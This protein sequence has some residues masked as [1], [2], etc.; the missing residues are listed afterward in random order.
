MGPYISWGQEDD[1]D[2]GR[3]I[4]VGLVVMGSTQS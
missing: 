1:G 2:D 4:I 3:G